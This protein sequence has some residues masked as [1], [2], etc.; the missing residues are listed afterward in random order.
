MNKK[1]LFLSIF[2]ILF[3]ASFP[4]GYANQ[5]ETIIIQEITLNSSNPYQAIQIEVGNNSRLQISVNAI[6]YLD[7]TVGILNE[8]NYNRFDIGYYVAEDEFFL[9]E[10]VLGNKESFKTLL[11]VEGIY[12]VIFIMESGSDTFNS[13]IEEIKINFARYVAGLITMVLGLVG[14]VISLVLLAR[15][16]IIEEEISLK[17]ITGRIND[18]TK[19]TVKAVTKIKITYIAILLFIIGLVITIY[20]FATA[21]VDLNIGFGWVMFFPAAISAVILL[22]IL[23]PFMVF[24][25]HRE[26]EKKRNINFRD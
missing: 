22:F 6:F 13:E 11:G 24:T 23:S 8:E 7:I 19:K 21:I 15:E 10:N 2:L 9:H 1:V 12:F 14:I 3:F 25:I 18:V 20:L 26:K 4:F 5:K 16:H 17:Q